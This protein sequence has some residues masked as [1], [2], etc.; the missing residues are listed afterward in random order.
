MTFKILFPRLLGGFASLIVVL[1]LGDCTIVRHDQKGGS[2]TADSAN[3]GE[4]DSTGYVE[5]NWTDKI[6][7]ELTGNAVELSTVLAALKADPDAARAKYGRRQ[8]ETAPFTFIVRGSFRVKAANL[9]SSAANVELAA[10][11]PTADGAVLVQIGPVIKTSAVRDVLSFVHF[12]D[13]TNQV[14]FANLS[15]A[16]NTRVKDTVVSGLDRDHLVGRTLTFTGAFAEDPSGQV[17]ITPVLLEVK[18]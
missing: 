13:F 14:D 2:A 10:P 18:K 8:E 7:P 11:A 4:F 15:R 17:L 9:E 1:A 3:S 16:I 6:V 12:G 5:K